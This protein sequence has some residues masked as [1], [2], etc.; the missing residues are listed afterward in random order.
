MHLLRSCKPLLA[1]IS[2]LCIVAGCGEGEKEAVNV[3]PPPEI[4]S[5]LPTQPIDAQYRGQA[6]HMPIPGG[7]PQEITV[8][9]MIGWEV[10][11]EP[12][13]DA[14]RSGRELQLFRIARAFLQFAWINPTDCDLHLEISDTV[15]KAAPRV[16]VETPV[17]SGFCA[18]RQNLKQQLANLG[19]P[20]TTN[21]GELQEPRPVEVLGLAFQDG[22]HERGTE[23]VKTVWELHPATISVLPQ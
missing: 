8:A 13:R 14:P 12:A 2:V 15:E 20:L 1:G 21:S 17:D 5:C 22:G 7:Q 19:V 6:K 16:I 10:D 11:T 18:S 9:T 3:P 4:C 23:R